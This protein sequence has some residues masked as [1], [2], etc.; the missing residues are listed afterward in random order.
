M[1]TGGDRV[2]MTYVGEEE[3]RVRKLVDGKL[4]LIGNGFA[5][6][7]KLGSVL[8]GGDKEEVIKG[9]ELCAKQSEPLVTEK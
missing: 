7:K 5:R 2:H 8:K 4:K 6:S 1:D 3:I 9:L